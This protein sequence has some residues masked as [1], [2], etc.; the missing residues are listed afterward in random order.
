MK[1]LVSIIIPTK[2]SQNSLAACLK[3]IRSQTYKNIEILVVDNHSSDKTIAIAKKYADKVFTKGPERSTQR[4]FG[5]DKSRGDY[6]AW[7][8]S[9]MQLEKNVIRECIDQMKRASAVI[10]PE[11]SIG[12][13]FW[14][15]CRSLEKSCYVGDDSIEGLRFIKKSVFK[16]VGMFSDDFISGEDWDITIRVRQRGYK[17]ARIKSYVFHDEGNLSLIKDLKKKYYYAK[18]SLPYVDRHIKEPSDVLAF[19][20]RPAYLKNWQKL[21]ADP[22]HTAGMFFMKTCEFGIGLIGFL[23]AKFASK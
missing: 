4:N 19:I 2:N 11:K 15:E 14:A 21:V 17:I 1:S 9:D 16:K 10:I 13:G 3:S 12:S 18:Q 22:L 5:V 8:D 20:I 7:F 23:E 6:I